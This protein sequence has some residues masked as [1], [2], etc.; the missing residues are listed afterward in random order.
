MVCCVVY[1]GEEVDFVVVICVTRYFYKTH[2]APRPRLSH[3]KPLRVLVV[4][5]VIFSYH[6]IENSSRRDEEVRRM[7]DVFLV[8]IIV[9]LRLCVQ[10][11]ATREGETINHINNRA[12]LLSLY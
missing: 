8:V 10:I 12:C 4:S 9:R 6:H 1:G 3:A 5:R 7:E 11:Q 2:F